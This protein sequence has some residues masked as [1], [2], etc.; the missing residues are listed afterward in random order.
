MG[1]C[2][3]RFTSWAGAAVRPIA[4]ERLERFVSMVE[5][6]EDATDAGELAPLL[7]GPGREIAR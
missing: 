7:A 6:L 2:V 1:D 5:H 4:R 3:E